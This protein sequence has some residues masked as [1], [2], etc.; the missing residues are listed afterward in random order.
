M[1]TKVQRAKAVLDALADTSVSNALALRVAKAFVF[2]Y[3]R[4]EVLT[5]NEEKAD[6]VV[7]VLRGFIKQ[8]VRD[9]EI[10]QA[11]EAARVATAPGAE[12]DVGVD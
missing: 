6:V 2:T 12:I 10:S 7:Q 4:E 1:A 11:M 8:V 9:S 3:R 5:T